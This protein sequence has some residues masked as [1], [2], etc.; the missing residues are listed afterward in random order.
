M[1]HTFTAIISKELEPLL[2]KEL[3]QIGLQNV[4]AEQGA[5]RFHG[6]YTAG[7]KAALWTRLASRILMRI[8]RFTCRDAHELYEGVQ[9]VQWKEYLSSTGSLW[10][11]F[12]GQSKTIRHSGFAAQRVKDAIVDQ[13]RDKNGGRPSI[14]K[15]APDLRLQVHLKNGVVTLNLDLCGPPLHLRTPNKHVLDAPLK[16]NLASALL[17]LSDWPKYA[18]QGLPLYDPMCGSGTLLIEAAHIAMNR[19][20]N[21]D[22]VD[23]GFKRWKQH[24]P[25]IWNTLVEEAK[26]LETPLPKGLIY[27]ADIN[28]QAIGYA[29]QNLAYHNLSHISLNKGSFFQLPPPTQTPGLLLAN[30]PYGERLEI[31]SD[32]AIFY[33]NISDTLKIKYLG[34]NAFLLSTTDCAKFIALKSAQKIPVFNGSLKCRLLQYPIRSEPPARFRSDS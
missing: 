1:N 28:P 31:G 19:A 22:R 20:P 2:Q 23:W 14:Q 8:H 32:L 11:D 21:L 17:L 4:V 18:K 29:Q 34:W 13:L 16:E 25:K 33:K 15:H 9:Q 3:R 24:S 30:P 6:D 27:G 5:V 7:L 12:V 10:I 26:D